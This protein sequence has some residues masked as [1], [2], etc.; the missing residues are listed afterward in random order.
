[1]SN[2]LLSYLEI[3]PITFSIL[4]GSFLSLSRPIGGFVFGVAFWKISRTVS[5][6]KNVKTYMIISGWG[7]FLIFSTDQAT[8][9]VVSPYPPFDIAIITVL[10]LGRIF[11]VVGS[12][13][14]SCACFG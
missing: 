13:Q 8:S 5:Y 4:L 2:L 14:F 12:L 1:M 3:D 11:D 6:E 10:N 9:Q 7:I